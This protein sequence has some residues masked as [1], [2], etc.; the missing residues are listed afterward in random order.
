MAV[1][2]VVPEGRALPVTQLELFGIPD[3]TRALGDLA[4]WHRTASGVRVVGFRARAIT[5]WHSS[6]A[7]VC[8]IR[9]W[10]TCARGRAKP[11]VPI[12][13]RVAS[14]WPDHTR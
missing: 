6:C 11:S 14:S 13:S 10:M 4:A 2:A 5:T 8:S 1:G 3:T 12:C 7:T 9:Q